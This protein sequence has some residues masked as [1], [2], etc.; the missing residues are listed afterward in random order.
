MKS[1]ICL[2]KD[3]VICISVNIFLL[4]KKKKKKLKPSRSF[5]SSIEGELCNFVFDRN[6]IQST[7]M[8]QKNEKKKFEEKLIVQMTREHAQKH[9]LFIDIF[10]LRFVHI[11]TT[12]IDFSLSN[13]TNYFVEKL[14]K[15][16]KH[17][18]VCV[19]RLRIACRV[20][21]SHQYSSQLLNFSIRFRPQK[22]A[23]NLI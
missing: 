12:I 16:K 7:T 4:S 13:A 10:L 15:K 11:Q 20:R 22:E 19:C 18:E 8:F 1:S 9:S 3:Y 21:I 2:L 14:K 6:L 5:K 23:E 17:I